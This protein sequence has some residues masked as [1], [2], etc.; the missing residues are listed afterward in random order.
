MVTVIVFKSQKPVWPLKY[1][2]NIF[3]MYAFILSVCCLKKMVIGIVQLKKSVSYSGQ[4]CMKIK[5]V[6]NR[7][8]CG[9]QMIGIGIGRGK[10]IGCQNRSVLREKNLYHNR[11]VCVKKE[12]VSES[13]SLRGK[14]WDSSSLREKNYRYRNRSVLREKMIGVRIGQFA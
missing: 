4:F 5:S 13:V 10:M 12:S 2:I 3:F 14:K 8:V 11:E 9:K 7:V 6:S 1:Q